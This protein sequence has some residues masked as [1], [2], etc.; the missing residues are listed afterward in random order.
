[1]EDNKQLLDRVQPFVP[2]FGDGWGALLIALQDLWAHA[3]RELSAE[4]FET[5]EKCI[6][7]L[8]LALDRRH[9]DSEVQLRIG[10]C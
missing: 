6:R 7:A 10:S 3:K 4:E 9:G 8:D 1:M 2:P 5:L